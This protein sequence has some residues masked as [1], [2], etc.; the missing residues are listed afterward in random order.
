MSK[1]PKK[2]LDYAGWSTNIF[3]N[4]SSPIDNLID[5]HGWVGFAV[6]FYL[7]QRAYSTNGYY[8]EWQFENAPSTARHMSCGMTSEIVRDTVALC[9]EVGLF[10]KAL[11]EEYGILT[12]CTIQ[13]R[14]MY[15]IEKRKASGRTVYGKYWLL[16][17]NET[18]SYILFMEN[19]IAEAECENSLPEN[20][21]ML[22]EKSDLNLKNSVTLPANGTKESKGKESKANQ[23]KLQYSTVKESTRQ[24]LGFAD[25]TAATPPIISSKNDLDDNEWVISEKG[26]SNEN[27]S[28]FGDNA[29]NSNDNADK[30]GN[31]T[32]ELCTKTDERYSN[33]CN[34]NNN[35]AVSSDSGSAKDEPP[36]TEKQLC[37]QYGRDNV[38]TYVQ[39]FEN[40]KIK[41]GITAHLDKWR[42]IAKWLK[43]DGVKKPDNSSFDP[44][45]VMEMI[46]A[47]YTRT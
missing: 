14:Y 28:V 9:L 34:L 46:M 37:K 24:D 41:K 20:S 27:Q 32:S 1:L 15:A 16:T 17:P 40:W 33:T 3:D 7:C 25:Q 4:E 23:S 42:I 31:N 8:Y 2:G 10:D 22:P 13:E 18:K 36:V 21:D 43:A 47:Q 39:R 12:N 6:Y 44:D 38:N 35:K 29:K 19:E 45:D 11:F 30:S 5:E 26:I